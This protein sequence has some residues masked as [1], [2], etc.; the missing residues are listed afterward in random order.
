MRGA[1]FAAEA[2]G[3]MRSALEVRRHLRATS[4]LK[5]FALAGALALFSAPAAS[6]RLVNVWV[7]GRADVVE[8]HAQRP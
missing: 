6:A 1:K 2:A 4:I 8:C 7:G 5:V 3:N